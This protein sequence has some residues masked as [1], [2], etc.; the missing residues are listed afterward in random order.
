M[1][2]GDALIYD[3]RDHVPI[4]NVFAIK[5]NKPDVC[6]TDL[7]HSVDI[8]SIS[9][10]Q[11]NIERGY[12]LEKIIE[13]LRNCKADIICL[14]EIDIHCIRSHNTNCAI[15]IAKSLKMKCICVIEFE[16]LN[17]N[18]VHGNAILSKMDFDLFHVINHTKIFD[19][20]EKGK[21][22]GEPRIGNRCTMVCNF[23]IAKCPILVY[24]AHLEIFTGIL[25]RVTQ[26]SEIFEFAAKANVK[27]QILCGDLNT[28]GHGIARFSPSY[29]NDQMR[30]K[31]IGYSES[32]FFYDRVLKF[33]VSDGE[34]NCNLQGYSL[35]E[36]VLKA[37][38]N[39]G[40]HEVFD[41]NEITLINYGGAFQGKLDWLLIKGFKVKNKNMFNED[42]DASDHKL[43]F[44]TLSAGEPQKKYVDNTIKDKSTR[45][46][47]YAVIF[48][49]SAMLLSIYLRNKK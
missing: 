28:M 38:R 21:S 20:A 19:W 15:E 2:F 11:W 44:C 33:N 17:E 47:I 41:L 39:P 42:Y 7:D 18:G 14:Q 48:A 9:V 30:W 40:F 10:V 23:S 12:Q 24:S 32:E 8:G 3:Y 49:S 25:G 31:S 35:S 37:A 27:N 5:D 29:C 1:K 13:L 16:E 34:L 36:E 26:I 4:E 6:F 45:I 43:L 46:M 22:R